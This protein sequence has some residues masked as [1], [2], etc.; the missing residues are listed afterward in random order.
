MTQ[1]GLEPA[2]PCSGGPAPGSDTPGM[3]QVVMLD[4]LLEVLLDIREE[5]EK[6]NAELRQFRQDS[7]Y[8]NAGKIINAG[9]IISQLD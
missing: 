8:R 2:T 5:L 1:A 6:T 9:N 3:A 4:T 7:F